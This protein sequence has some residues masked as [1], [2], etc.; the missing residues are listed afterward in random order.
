MVLPYYKRLSKVSKKIYLE[1]DG[2]RFFDFPEPER[3]FP[4]CHKLAEI[5]GAGDQPNT[6]YLVQAL[7]DSLAKV[8]RV[9]SVTIKVLKKR[10]SNHYGELHGLYEAWHDRRRLPVI[11]L[12]MRT[13]KRKQ[14][15]AFKTFLRT[16]AH[17]WMHHMDYCYFRL[18]D[19]LHTEGFYA[20]EHLLYKYLVGEFSLQT[21]SA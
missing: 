5:L 15:V 7:A 2:I 10:P 9:R 19:S 18:K 6:Q 12:W 13:A 20:R 16:F 3:F 4:L 21:Q 17:E 8:F 11:T 14:V 1:S